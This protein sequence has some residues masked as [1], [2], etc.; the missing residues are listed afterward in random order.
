MKYRKEIDGLRAIAVLPV[1]L[2]HA[3]FKSF[4]GGFVGVDI[5]FVISGYLITT[6]IL[7]ELEHDKFS[8]VNF[9]ERRARRILPA[10]F[11]VML[12]CLPFAWLWL[13]PSDMQD[14]S[15]SLVAVST[16]SSNVL[17]WRSSGYFDAASELK[18][19]LHTWSL[20]IEEQYYVFFPLFMMLFWKLG[21]KWLLIA[22]GFVFFAILSQWGVYAKPVASFY[23]LPTRS[24][25]LLVGAFAAFYMSSSIYKEH[26][27]GINEIAGWL[28]ICL[29]ITSIAIYSNN[30]PFPGLYAVPPVL[31]TLLVI[32]YANQYTTVGK[33]VGNKLFVGVGLISYSAYLWHQPLFAFARHRSLLEPSTAVLLSISVASLILA[34]FSWSFVEAPFRNK[35]IINRKQIFAFGVAGS[36]VFIIIGFL[37]V[38][39]KGYFTHRPNIA[40]A[41]SLS[42]RIKGNYGLS[43]E[44]EGN[45]NLTPSCSTSENPE[46][47]LWGDSYAMHLAQGLLASKPDIKLVQM[48]RSVCAP[49]LDIAPFDKK[50]PIAWGENCMAGNDQAFEYLKN[51]KTIKYV[52]LGSPFVQIVSKD[53]KVL[54]KEGKIVLGQ[55][56]ALNAM[57]DTIK[58]IRELGKIPVVFSTTPQNGKDIG[59]CLAKSVFYK[60]D[61]DS[62]DMLY[63]DV[64]SNQVDVLNF[65]QE[66]SQ[67]AFVVNL[68][69]FL[70]KDDICKSSY[71][72]VFIY[73]DYG[74]LS[75]EGSAYLGKKMNFYQLLVE[76]E[77][78]SSAYISSR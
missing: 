52:V 65:L 71:D 69:D 32:L 1:I 67:Y 63:S 43:R 34:Y 27:R 9:Y 10:L 11:F 77:Y 29:I 26:R 39:T 73:R 55:D 41:A 59:K 24:W 2:F 8:I 25:E 62:C 42:D 50:S 75:H 22:L 30:T 6:I 74:H 12:V 78:N 70:C 57:K 76:A 4:S 16:F 64:L 18:P 48:T 66:I 68:A 37:G 21:K 36:F 49:L 56:V 72:D 60:A 40:L 54:T 28:G 45:Y 38:F 14:F 3:G 53:A 31:G 51:S 33:F 23:L 46:V 44:C 5:F 58:K 7:G 35:S 61:V 17:F 47:L 20:A 13:F 15:K 19:L